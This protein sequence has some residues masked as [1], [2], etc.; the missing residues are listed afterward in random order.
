MAHRLNERVIAKRKLY[1]FHQDQ[2]RQCRVAAP[3]RFNALKAKVDSAI[4]EEREQ[5]K[6]RENREADKIN[7]EFDLRNEK[8]FEENRKISEEVR[9]KNEEIGKNDEE[10]RKN[11]EERERRLQSNKQDSE[12]RFAPVEHKRCGLLEDIENI[13]D[14]IEPQIAKLEKSLQDAKRK[15]DDLMMNRGDEVE[16]PFGLDRSVTDALDMPLDIAAAKRINRTLSCL[17]FVEGVGRE[18]YN[19]RIDGYDGVWR[20]VDEI[21]V[22]ARIKFPTIVGCI[23]S[24]GVLIT[25]W[26]EGNMHTYLLDINTKSTEKVISSTDKSCVVSCASL[27]DGKIVC[28]KRRAGCRAVASGQRLTGCITVYDREWKMVIDVTI[29]TNNTQDDTWVYAAADPEGMIIA[30]EW[31]QSNIYIINPNDGNTLRTIT[32]RENAAVRGVVSSGLILAQPSSDNCRV[33]KINGGRGHSEIPFR[34]IIRNACIDPLTDALYVV[35]TG[36][37]YKTCVIE[38]VITKCRSKKKKEKVASICLSRRLSGINERRTHLA[39]SQVIMT[40]SGK[41]IACDGNSIHCITKDVY[42]I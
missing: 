38:H 16:G 17:R 28:G 19:G 21:N 7:H 29:P 8:I 24:S 13:Q 35:T 37:E 20:L 42:S 41:L 1:N 12:R 2:V 25:D 22:M 11:N 34:N 3:A 5:E 33:L 14:V 18:R 27:Y 6:D 26:D 30:A 4:D 36:N 39:S 9:K 23:D 32:S 15:L 40:S 10:I 31:G